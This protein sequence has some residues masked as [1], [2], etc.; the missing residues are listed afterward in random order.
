MVGP[1]KGDGF[2]GLFGKIYG[3][4]SLPYNKDKTWLGTTSF[5]IGSLGAILF[6]A[7]MFTRYGWIYLPNWDVFVTKM[8]TV[9][10]LSAMVESL[11]ICTLA[12]L[13]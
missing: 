2:A 12:L 7:T 13:E 5:I 11:P 1:W 8:I 3:R 6:F 4:S 10:G 9:V